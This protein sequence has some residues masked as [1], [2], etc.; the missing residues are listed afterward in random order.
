MV[1][2]DY[3]NCNN[4]EFEQCDFLLTNDCPSTCVYAIDIG[5]VG[6][7]QPPRPEVTKKLVDKL[8]EEDMSDY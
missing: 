1:L 4:P 5:G 3:I 6:M 2:P 8:F 7:D